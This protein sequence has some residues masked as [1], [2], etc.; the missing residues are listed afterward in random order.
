MPLMSNWRGAEVKA[1]LYWRIILSGTCSKRH[2][3]SISP[4]SF[5][6][7][8]VECFLVLSSRMQI[9]SCFK[10]FVWMKNSVEV[11]LTRGMSSGLWSRAD[12]EKIGSRLFYENA[13]KLYNVSTV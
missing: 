13:S 3:T 10:R 8:M 7:D 5:T 1:T 4:F 12:A 6:Q 9:L 2:V 11:A